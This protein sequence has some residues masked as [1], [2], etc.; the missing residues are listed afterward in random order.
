MVEQPGQF[1]RRKIGVGQQAGHL[2]DRLLV[3]GLAQGGAFRRGA[4]VLPDDGVMDR[5]ARGAIPDHHRLALVGDA[6]GGHLRSLNP[7]PRQNSATGAQHARPQIFGVMLDPAGSGIDLAELFLCGSDQLKL[8]VEQKGTRRGGALV[9]RQDIAGH[10]F[11]S[12]SPSCRDEP[13]HRYTRSRNLPP[14][15]R[16][17]QRQMLDFERRRPRERSPCPC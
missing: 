1:G 6:D 9:D 4:A 2:G 15:L 12:R 17:G 5:L 3:P 13:S 7:C 16:R 14:V 8:G 10:G 11:R